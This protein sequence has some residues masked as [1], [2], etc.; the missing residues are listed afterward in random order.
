[1]S[2]N[3]Q[4]D[5]MLRMNEFTQVK[6]DYSIRN[7]AYGDRKI[8][9]LY[10][11]LKKTPRYTQGEIPH[12]W[13]IKERNIIPD[14]VIGSDGLGYTRPE[15]LLFVSRKDQE[16]FL[17]GEGFTDVHAIGHPI[18]YLK[19]VGN[20]SRIKDSLLVMPAHSLRETTEDWR[21]LD[22]AYFKFLSEHISNF[23]YIALCLHPEDIK[24]KN[25]TMVSQLIPQRIEG[26]DEKDANSYE[27][28]AVLF[29]MFEYVTTNRLGSHV[30]YASY[31]G[32]KVSVCGPWEFK[33]E[34]Y[35]T[36][37]FYRNSPSILDIEERWYKSS[38]L[39]RWYPQFFCS[40]IDA[41]SN[42]EW[43]KSEL[44]FECRKSQRELIDLFGWRS[45]T[46]LYLLLRDVTRRFLKILS[47]R[48]TR[49]A[50]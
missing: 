39:Q 30:A 10:A 41:V 46:Q 19:D 32:S 40:P 20:Y 18:I 8:L 49:L 38:S 15:K 37:D 33:K 43:A 6:R 31:F 16:T 36:M 5:R 13:I 26:A 47:F 1:M 12:S 44:G 17:R 11:G 27:R 23:S 24:K 21:E 3:Q 9:S 7:H 35:L 22:K 34:E 14:F 48:N 29:S 50:S 4:H 45:S 42:I 2:P 28:M 25:W